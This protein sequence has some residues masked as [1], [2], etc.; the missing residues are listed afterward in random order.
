[1]VKIYDIIKSGVNTMAKLMKK[2]LSNFKD[3]TDYYNYLVQ[4]T[5]NH[6]Y[7]DIT[8][9]WLIDNY[10]LL[11]EH[12]NNIVNNK[13]K[14]KKNYKAVQKNYLVLKNIVAK[15]N[16]NINFKYLV[17]EL[18]RYQ[19]ETK[20]NFTYKELECIVPT[21]VFIYTEKLNNLCREEYK[22]LVDN[23]DVQNIIQTKNNLT[24]SSFIQEGFDV[25]NN[26]HYIFQINNQLYKVKNSSEIF[27]ALNEYLQGQGSRKKPD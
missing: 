15:R 3:I 12:K 26:G 19:K 20:D 10:Y 4:K 25:K 16:Y 27:K 8:N 21:L 23:E 5:K 17:E 2:F 24:L 14:I 13:K 7:V 1:M 6:E 9:E 11:A 22:K 18:K